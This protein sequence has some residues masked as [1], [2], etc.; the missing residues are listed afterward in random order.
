MELFLRWEPGGWNGCGG[1]WSSVVVSGWLGLD[2]SGERDW[3]GVIGRNWIGVVGGIGLE[4][5]VGGW[6]GLVEVGCG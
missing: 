2:W 6:L 4:W 3:I 1:V 5:L